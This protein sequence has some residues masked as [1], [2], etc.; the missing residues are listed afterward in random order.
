[1][2]DLDLLPSAF[3]DASVQA[4][5]LGIRVKDTSR[6]GTFQLGPE[7]DLK[8]FSEKRSG[9][10]LINAGVYF[11]RGNLPAKFPTYRPLSFEM[12]VF[13]HLLAQGVK[14]QVCSVDTPFL[15]IGTEDTLNQADEFITL[16]QGSFL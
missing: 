12:D 8:C 5:V 2:A 4:A 14:I 7:G 16:H 11:L 6:Y 13:P 9:S 10:G 1:L 3:E 15:D